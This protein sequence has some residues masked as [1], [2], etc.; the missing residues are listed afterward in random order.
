MKTAIAALAAALAA[1]FA[2][3]APIVLENGQMRLTLDSR[4]W[5]ESLVVKATGEECLKPGV[6]LPLATLTQN[7]AYDNEY[8]LLL[9]ADVW[10]HR[11]NRIEL[12]GD[13]LR[14]GFEDEFHTLVLK[15]RVTRD[16][17]SFAYDRIDYSY[18]AFGDKRRTEVDALTLVQLPVA[19]RRRYGRTLNAV[20]DDR[21]A[22]AL[23]A[24]SVVTHAGA[25]QDGTWRSEGWRR[26]FAA[27]EERVGFA[28]AQAVL[29]AAGG[30]EGLLDGIDAAEGDLDLPRGVR[31]RRHP[32]HAASYLSLGDLTPD[33][34]DAQIGLLKEAGFRLALGC[35]TCF[36]DTNGSY[37]WKKCCPN[38]L[39]DLVAAA[40]RFRAAGIVLG[41]HDYHTK[42]STND[43]MWTG[44]RP[45]PRFAT[46]AEITLAADIGPDDAVIPVQGNPR[47]LRTEPGRRFV[48][49][50]DE[51]IEYGSYTTAKPYRLLDCRR[52]V[53]GSPRTAHRRNDYGRHIDV[54]DWNYFIRYDQETEIQDEV[55]GRLASALN[56]SGMHRFVYFDG[57]EDVPQPFWHYVPLA[58]K[59]VWDRLSPA[60][61]MGECALKSHFGWHMFSR[62]NAFDRFIP[63]HTRL[64]MKKYVLRGAREAADDFS[65]V[66]FGWLSLYLPDYEFP[67]KSDSQYRRQTEIRRTIGTQPDMYEYV[68]SKA[69]AWNCPLSLAGGFYPRAL[70]HPRLHDLLAVLKRWEDA[71]LGGRLS[72][73]QREML[74][75]P[76]R[77]WFI[78]PG[79]EAQPE[80]VEYRPVTKD[81]ERPLRAFSYTRGKTAGIVYWNA[82]AAETPA[83]EIPGARMRIDLGRRLIESDDRMEAELVKAFRARCVSFR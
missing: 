76:D 64:A 30:G 59:R 75:D 63:E 80:L 56:A 62:G 20:W 81:D 2:L 48:F 43:V 19:D 65:A 72:A 66:N 31:A 40:D 18:E 25:A 38:G 55:A 54:D 46:V 14:I 23:M 28:G 41:M 71:K 1:P 42:C 12:V 9:P 53:N 51:L 49:L 34:V 57:A 15:V 17:L 11:A 24:G 29:V 77:E 78:Y 22:L 3:S 4:G 45:D 7:R 5:S 39:K 67:R 37:P 10:E 47:R 35:T 52:G 73:A 74:K 36:A 16:Y 68:A 32:L 79:T 33:A 8:K 26:L 27:A 58:Q 82:I 83:V 13:E 69:A 44:G 70:K 60:P 21:A 6:R 50:G 61:A